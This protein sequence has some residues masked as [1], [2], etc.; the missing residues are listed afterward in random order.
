MK[1][2]LKLKRKKEEEVDFSKA[3]RSEWYEG[4]EWVRGR[5]IGEGGFGRVNLAHFRP[6][7]KKFKGMPCVVAVKSCP[8]STSCSAELAAEKR[9][10]DGLTDCPFIVRCL[11]SDVTFDPDGDE[12]RLN[13]FLEFA[14]KGSLL[15]RVCASPLPEPEVGRLTRCLVAALE[16]VH[17][18][19]LVH[20]DV[21]LDNVLLFPDD[22]AKLADFGLARPA[23]DG[24]PGVVCGSTP[25]WAPEMVTGGGIQ[26]QAADVWAVGWVALGMLTGTL[27][28]DHRGT[29]SDQQ[30]VEAI[31]AECPLPLERR[32][33]FSH[34]AED[35][36]CQCFRRDPLERPTAAELLTHPFL[37]SPQ[38][39]RT[40]LE[41]RPVKRL[42][43][44]LRSPAADPIVTAGDQFVLEPQPRPVKRLRFK[45]RP[46]PPNITPPIFGC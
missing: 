41:P 13:V 33:V 21:K 1:I 45:L 2:L 26:G 36:L 19:G 39:D 40:V 30:L 15:D 11:G 14:P 12:R 27:P 17:R 46:P 7:S 23:E 22:V 10:L 37:Q 44:K 9:I 35:F 4:R 34:S 8:L 42:R 29:L 24:Q 28:W 25:Y 16:R 6:D 31:A 18:Q 20:C 43:I 38:E 5:V 3:E 32:G